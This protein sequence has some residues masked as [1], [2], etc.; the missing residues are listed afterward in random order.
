M[1]Q[2][3]K[4]QREDL[5]SEMKLELERSKEELNQQLENGLQ[6]ELEVSQKG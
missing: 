2:L 6:G 3:H 4:K 5:E 1:E